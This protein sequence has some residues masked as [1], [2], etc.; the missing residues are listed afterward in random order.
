M[1]RRMVIQVG[2]YLGQSKISLQIHTAEPAYLIGSLVMDPSPN[3]SRTG[4]SAINTT[5]NFTRSRKQET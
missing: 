1:P 4:G 3:I 5:G 2:I